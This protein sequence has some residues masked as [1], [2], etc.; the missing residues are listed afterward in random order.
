MFPF[1]V[2]QIFRGSFKLSWGH[3][4]LP[5]WY[6]NRVDLPSVW[7]KIS[8]VHRDT[9]SSSKW[10]LLSGV[11]E[12]YGADS[13]GLLPADV[14]Q[15]GYSCLGEERAVLSTPA[16]PGKI[17]TPVNEAAHLPA[18]GP[19]NIIGVYLCR[20]NTLA[21]NPVCLHGFLCFEKMFHFEITISPRK[22]QKNSMEC[23]LLF[24]QCISLFICNYALL[25]TSELL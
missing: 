20:S 8:W 13:E 16:G 12:N 24:V 11:A 2:D 4:K 15:G 6:V 22:L 19:W 17:S 3:R 21:V 23:S 18:M 10:G 1:N 7:N 14:A 5:Q 25:P 9:L